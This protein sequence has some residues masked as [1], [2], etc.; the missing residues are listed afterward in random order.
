MDSIAIKSRLLVGMYDGATVT[1]EPGRVVVQV[2]VRTGK[3][4]E[5][6]A[7]MLSPSAYAD[8]QFVFDRGPLTSGCHTSMS[9]KRE[10]RSA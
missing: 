7:L 2:W 4:R 10:R 5:R 1:H 9:Q 6:V 8:L 3:A